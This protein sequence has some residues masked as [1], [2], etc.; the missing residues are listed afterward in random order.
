MNVGMVGILAIRGCSFACTLGGLF[1]F[2]IVG[3]FRGATL[4]AFIA[5]LHVSVSS[6]Q[7]VWLPRLPCR[8]AMTDSGILNKFPI[9]IASKCNERGNRTCWT[10][11]DGGLL[12]LSP[13]NDSGI[14]WDSATFDCHTCLIG[15]Q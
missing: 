10:F 11:R 13:R 6:V 2:L 15:S 9:V 5:S 4:V 12:R 7:D 3:R 14:F 8:L 1:A